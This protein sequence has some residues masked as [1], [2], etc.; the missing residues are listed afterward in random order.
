MSV[1]QKICTGSI[2]LLLPLLMVLSS[3]TGCLRTS[4]SGDSELEINFKNPPESAKPRVWWHWMNGNITREGIRK[5]LEWMHRTGIGGFQNFDA[6]LETPQIVEKRLVYMTPEW[7]DAFRFTTEFADSLG[8]EMAI[9]GS[10]GWSES[11]G[12]WVPPSEGMKKYVW[13]ELTIEGGKPFQGKLPQPPTATGPFMNLFLDNPFSPNGREE[14]LPEYYADAAVIA[15]R[16]PDADL[17][18]SEPNPKVTSSGGRF[19]PEMLTDGDLVTSSLLPLVPPGEKSWIQ[20]EFERPRTIRSISMVGGGNPGRFGRG[21]SREVRMLESGNDGR[22]FTEVVE[23]VTGGVA[24]NT[25]TFPP[26]TAK[27]FRITVKT[28]EPLEEPD[29]LA[30]SFGARSETDRGPSGTE[31][32]EIVLHSVPRINRFEQKAGFATIIGAENYITPEIP[33]GEAIRGADVV[34][35]TGMMDGEGNL[36][37]TPPEGRWNIIR[38]GYSLTGH[39]NSPASLEATGLEVDKLDPGYVRNYFTNYLDQYKDATGGLMGARGLHYVITDSWEA[40]TANWTDRMIG[41]FNKRNSYDIIPWLPVLTGRIV[42]SSRASEKF[43]WDFRY[44]LEAMVA[45]YHYDELTTI[46]H[47]REMGR[48]TES[49][50]GGR[51]FIGDGMEVKRGADIPMSATWTPGGFGQS[52]SEG[53]DIRHET[54]IRE[55]ASVAH[56]YGQNLVAAESLTAIGNTWAYAPQRLKPTADF[57]LASGLNRFVIHTSVHQP[58]DD[59][60]PGL[61]LGPFGQWFTRHETWA[62]QAKPWVDYLAR[63]SY[64][65][66][67]GKFV[68]DLIYI[69]GQGTNLTALF[70]DHLPPVPEGFNYDFLNAGAVPAVLSVRNSN[71]ITESGMSYRLLALDESARYMTLPVLRKLEEL[72]HAGAMVVGQKP[73]NTPSLNDDELEFSEIADRMWPDEHGVTEIGSGKVYGGYDIG[74]VLE[75]LQI[76][77]DF[78]YSDRDTG[79]RMKFVHRSL[80][81]GDIYWVNTESR[82]SATR[83]VSFLVSGRE[84]EIWDPVTG[85]IVPASYTMEN[86][87]TEVTLPMDPEDAL[88]VVFRNKTSKKANHLPEVVEQPVETV[89]G[90]WEV[91]F[92]AGRGAPEQAVFNELTRWDENDDPGIRYFSGTASYSR[93]VNVPGEWLLDN[94]ELWLDLGE[95]KN[96][97]E[98]LVNGQSVG[99]AWKTPF[100]VNISKAIHAG[101]NQ[102]V[103]KVTNLWVNR[104]I[105]DQQPGV[106][107]P[108]TYTTEAFYRAD[109]PLLPSGLLGPVKIISRSNAEPQ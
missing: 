106:T 100:R 69:Y 44:T 99:I 19:T 83:Q 35:L 57:M 60:I 51:A 103:V 43:L 62:G 3:T 91:K 16:I 102:L 17:S 84:P 54:D 8:L 46:L 87:R 31:I 25:V 6:S 33:S 96:L 50:E 72:A 28:P 90:P 12:P 11:G 48:Y 93:T 36:E 45:E 14:G 37:W 105:G 97:A 56:I 15:Y 29:P 22:N 4:G 107:D 30:G 70:G 5:D 40:G 71:L 18:V 82:E 26:V 34:N 92:Q 81:N 20:F 58:V 24:Q 85:G 74:E 63:S 78:E 38:I 94:Q 104:L 67:Q 89:S 10:P 52:E 7:K 23:I 75:E 65:L 21:R 1:T 86:G 73:V 2:H 101:E 41:E 59:K 80:G 66:Q 98:V 76:P 42:E 88:F 53:V 95:V 108:V 61:S 47:E 27:Y 32:A 68:A 49:H 55:S 9:A 79:G 13:S 77:P 109:S 39:Q 64:M